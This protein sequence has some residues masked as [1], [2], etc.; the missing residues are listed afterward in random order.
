LKEIGEKILGWYGVGP[1]PN[2]SLAKRH[3]LASDTFEDFENFKHFSKLQT[4]FKMRA[5]KTFEKIQSFEL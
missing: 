5:F 2:G 3:Q 4:P 1:N